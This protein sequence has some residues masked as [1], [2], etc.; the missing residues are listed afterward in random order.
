MNL[1]V[2]RTHQHPLLRLIKIIF[3]FERQVKPFCKDKTFGL[4]NSNKK[5]VHDIIVFRCLQIF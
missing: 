2:K 1:Q 5:S 4:L 3:V